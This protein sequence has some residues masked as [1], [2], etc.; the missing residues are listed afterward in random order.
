MSGSFRW[1]A[2]CLADDPF[3]GDDGGSGYSDRILSDKMVTNR[4]GGTCQTCAGD[5]EPGIRNRVRAE[6]YDGDLMRF[7]WCQL[8]CFGMAIAGIGRDS[9][10]ERQIA[11]GNERRAALPVTPAGEE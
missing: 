5:C 3:A 2:E 6:V 9:L 1:E 11:L 10:I 7:R 8:C 4:K